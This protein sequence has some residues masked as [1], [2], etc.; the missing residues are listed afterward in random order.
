M[1][2]KVDEIREKMV[3][4]EKQYNPFTDFNFKNDLSIEEYIYQLGNWFNNLID[5]F[6]SLEDTAI[7][8]NEQATESAESAATSATAAAESAAAAAESAAKAEET[9]DNSISAIQ[10]AGQTVINS[11]PA[12]YTTLT[13]N[14]NTLKSN[15]N[16]VP[17]STNL[18]QDTL[19][20]G[21]SIVRYDPSTTNKP[22]SNGYGTCAYYTYYQGNNKWYT[23]VANTTS[24]KQYIAYKTNAA[25]W[26]EWQQLPS[27]EEI[28]ELNDNAKDSA[29]KMFPKE[30]IANNTDIN[31]VLIG[32]WYCASNA[33][34]N[35]LSNL[36]NGVS[37]V[38]RL[39]VIS[40]TRDGVTNPAESVPWI[41]RMQFIVD[42][43]G[44]IFLRFGD[45]EGST[46][47]FIWGSWKSL[48]L[49]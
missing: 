41:R 7:E 11:I 19:P 14:V 28:N 1:S 44:S 16:E 6:K 37:S 49:T 26:L 3:K 20:N 21:F 27:R 36:P 32:D 23:A 17:L 34:K 47:S 38:F 42:S 46:T 43:N 22:D 45:R 12:D 15:L 2:N 40:I 8:V 18:L 31:N 30:V 5:K 4:L 24:N 35:S 13:N 33:T 48:T 9:V 29:L 39:Q 25:N 10:L